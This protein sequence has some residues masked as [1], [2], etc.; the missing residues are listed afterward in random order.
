MQWGFGHTY[1]D[2]WMDGHHSVVE[3]AV[4][5][6]QRRQRTEEVGVELGKK[7]AGVASEYERLHTYIFQCKPT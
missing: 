5:L 4:E 2:R 1:T 7:E 6:N 3:I